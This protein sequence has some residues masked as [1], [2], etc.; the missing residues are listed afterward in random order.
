[1]STLDETTRLSIIAVPVLPQFVVLHVS[2]YLRSCDNERTVEQKTRV[3]HSDTDTPRRTSESH[4]AAKRND[5]GEAKKDAS[6]R[7]R[8]AACCREEKQ[9]HKKQKKKQKAEKKIPKTKDEDENNKTERFE[10]GGTG[11]VWQDNN[12]N[13]AMPAGRERDKGGAEDGRM[14]ACTVNKKDGPKTK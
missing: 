13:K 11:G 4:G 5:M 2:S 7:R 3:A 6:V 9:Q 14:S 8:D 1:M 12:K 10:K